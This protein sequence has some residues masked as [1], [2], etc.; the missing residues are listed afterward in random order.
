LRLRDPLEARRQLSPRIEEEAA[1][2]LVELIA[3]TGALLRGHFRL[4]SGPHTEYF[5]RFGQLAYRA[6]NAA[7]I[8]RVAVDALGLAPGSDAVV[9]SADNAGR[10]FASALARVVGSGEASVAIDQGRRPTRE[11]ARGTLEGAATVIVALDVVTTGASARAL[12][13]VARAAT[14]D[15][16]VVAFARLGANL[17]QV[18]GVSVESLFDARWTRYAPSDCALCRAGHPLVPGF[19]LN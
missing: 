4:Q 11:V 16:R 2:P 1:A 10:F 9:L 12:L 5:L 17:D 6:E 8:A 15:V 18:D 3:S 19:E 14:E 13:D 7:L